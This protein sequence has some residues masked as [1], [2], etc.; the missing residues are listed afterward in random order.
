MTYLAPASF[1]TDSLDE[2]CRGLALDDVPDA[3]L[4]AAIARLSQRIDDWCGD[5]FEAE[6]AYTLVA[7]GT[8]LGRLYLDKRCRAV[9]SVKIRQVDGTLSAA[10][11]TTAYRL[12]S[13]LNT[14][15]TARVNGSNLDW[16]E[17]VYGAAGLPATTWGYGPYVWPCETNAIEIVG[18]FSWTAVPGDIQRAL[19]MLVYDHF[20]D[21]R[22]AL[23]AAESVQTDTVVVRYVQPNP[24]AGL[25][26]GIPDV[27]GII[28]DYRRAPR[29]MIG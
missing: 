28:G 18:D 26:S 1:R 10:A 6:A 29:V 11:A 17:L 7:T 3:P 9:T 25:Y 12:R 22:P 20:H 23:R 5:H 21:I 24:A 15:G 19:A 27:D 8:G 2:A 13:S 4:T 16:L 14:A